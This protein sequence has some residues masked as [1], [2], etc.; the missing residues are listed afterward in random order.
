MLRKKHRVYSGKDNALRIYNFGLRKRLLLSLAGEPAG[1]TFRGSENRDQPS[2]QSRIHNWQCFVG[3]AG[4]SRRDAFG[5]TRDLL[6]FNSR[7]WPTYWLPLIT[8]DQECVVPQLHVPHQPK[9]I[10]HKSVGFSS[11]Q[12]SKFHC[13]SGGI[14]PK[15]CLWQNPRPLV[16]SPDCTQGKKIPH[17]MRD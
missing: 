8:A 10:P 17:A 7:V 4:F 6:P 16:P 2:P 12:T 13:R 9:K 11:I 3:A 14:L 1:G 5:R 15:G